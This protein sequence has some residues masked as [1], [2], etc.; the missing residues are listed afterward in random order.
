MKI[1]ID[2]SDVGHLISAWCCLMP[3]IPHGGNFQPNFEIFGQMLLRERIVFLEESMCISAENLLEL[4]YCKIVCLAES[5]LWSF[6]GT[7]TDLVTLSPAVVPGVSQPDVEILMEFCSRVL[8]PASCVLS[9]PPNR[10]FKGVGHSRP[11][12]GSGW[13]NSVGV[14]GDPGPK[15]PL[16]D[17]QEGRP[18]VCPS[19]DLL[20]A[21]ILKILSL[22]LVIIVY[23]L[24][25]NRSY[26]E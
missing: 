24:G 22:T 9:S 7:V 18:A 11:A 3:A 5:F 8:L 16:L 25:L 17:I 15:A 26:R 19:L 10:E 2:G 4:E 21:R 1:I 12:E 23:V 20:E 14:E 6:R 13:E